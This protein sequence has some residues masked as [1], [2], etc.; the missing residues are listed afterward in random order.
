[1]GDCKRLH[2]EE[3]YL[4]SSPTIIQVLKSSR[5]RW[6][7]HMAFMGGRRGTNRVLIWRPK[8]KRPLE[9]PRQRWEDNIKMNV[10][11]V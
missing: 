1:M 9:R 4:Y 7:G 8:G 2:N 6:V 11:E 10:Q 3:L 5:M